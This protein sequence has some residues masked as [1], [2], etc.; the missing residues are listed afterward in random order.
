MSSICHTQSP[1]PAHV[2]LQRRMWFLCT[3]EQIVDTIITSEMT[4]P[5]FLKFFSQMTR[6]GWNKLILGMPVSMAPGTSHMWLWELNWRG[7]HLPIPELNYWDEMMNWEIDD[8]VKRTGNQCGLQELPKSERDIYVE[9][10]PVTKMKAVVDYY[11]HYSHNH[12]C[13]VQ[14]YD[15]PEESWQMYSDL[16]E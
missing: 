7:E 15:N 12:S 6:N 3:G 5:V 8:E 10:Y 16:F 13:L 2:P 9:N 1:T 14:L 4:E 11:S